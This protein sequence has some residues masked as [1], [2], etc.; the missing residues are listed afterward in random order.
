[1][2][3]WRKRAFYGGMAVLEL[4]A[5]GDAKTR[6]LESGDV[7]MFKAESITQIDETDKLR[8]LRRYISQIQKSK[9]EMG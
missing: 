4:A 7:H 5:V 3:I 6:V 2:I 8:E 1:M 9:E